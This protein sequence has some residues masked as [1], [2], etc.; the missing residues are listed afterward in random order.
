MK[1]FQK[2]AIGLLGLTNPEM[3]IPRPKSDATKSDV[4][5]TAKLETAHGRG[6]TAQRSPRAGRFV[7]ALRAL[8]FMITVLA[9]GSRM[10]PLGD[11]S[12]LLRDLRASARLSIGSDE[13]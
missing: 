5:S 11:N 6:S 4:T 13:G 8:K 3:F 7:R 9:T 1:Q 12:R 10:V 2:I